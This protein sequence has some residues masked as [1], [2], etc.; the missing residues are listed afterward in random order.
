MINARSLMNK[1]DMFKLTVHKYNPDIIGIT[2][3]WCIHQLSLQLTDYDLFRCDR[4][5]DNRGGGVLLY[6]KSELKPI[7]VQLT[8]SFVDYTC[9]K[10]GNLT[11][12]IM[13]PINE[14]RNS[15]TRQQC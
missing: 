12:V 2:E 14:Q 10:V 15:R 11:I 13:L 4:K 7:E 5:S 9:C 1:L 6:V 3:S 8:S